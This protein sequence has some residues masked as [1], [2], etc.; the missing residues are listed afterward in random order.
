MNIKKKLL[1]VYLNEFNLEYLKYGANK[2]KFE[3]LKRLLSLKKIKTFTKD[4]IQ[5]KNLDPWVQTVSISS[6]K[7]SKNHN[8]F[9]LGQRIPKKVNYIWDILTKKKIDCF[10]WGTMNST[11]KINN[12]MKLFFPDPWNYISKAHPKNLQNIHA[13]PR[14]YAKNYL[15]VNLLKLFKYSVKFLIGIIDSKIIL[16]LLKNTDLIIKSVFLKKLN[17][18]TLFFLFDLISLHIFSLKT[19]T[20]SKHFSLIFLNSLAHFQHNNWDEKENEKLYFTFVDRITKNIFDIYDKHNSLIIFNGFKQKKIKV[21]FLIRPLNPQLFLKKIINFKKLEQDMTNGGFIFFK[22]QK[23]TIKSYKV[24]KNY[25]VSGFYLFEVNQKK[26]NS[27]YYKINIKTFKYLT[28]NNLHLFSDDKLFSFLSYERNIRK[29][30]N[31]N[32]INRVEIKELLDNVKL[33][34]T[35]GAHSFQGD[36]LI[37]NFRIKENIKNIENHKI[38][39]LINNFY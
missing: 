27:F 25:K 24:I 10:V 33:I 31:N 13:L 34:K 19:I 30:P 9:K 32:K 5:N 29:N 16:F 20:N 36:I 28:K 8:V 22:N 1:A 4:K 2:Y 18:F 35:T 26:N 6:G 12:C 14:Y 39:N 11:Y 37:E 3:N 15:D 21:E 23:E 17:N 38:F 7:S